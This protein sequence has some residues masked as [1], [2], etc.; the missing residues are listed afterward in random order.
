MNNR[1]QL[2]PDTMPEGC[3]PTY[4]KIWG[5]INEKCRSVRAHCENLWKDFRK[6]ADDHFL[7]E[8][9]LR[10]HQRW[11]EMYLTVS[12]IRAGFAIEDSDRKSGPDLLLLIGGRR[13][14]IEAVCTE[15]GGPGNPDSV[16]E[17]ETNV[18]RDIPLRQYVL[19]LRNSLQEKSNKLRQYIQDDIILP[20]DLTVVAINVGGIPF[21][22]VDMDECIKRS[23]YGIGDL[24]LSVNKSTGKLARIQRESLTSIAK[25]SGKPVGVR[26]LIDGSMEH[27]S[28]LLESGA[29]AANL[30]RKFGEDFIL[31]PNLISTRQWP[32]GILPLGREWRFSDSGEEWDG[33]LMNPLPSEHPP[34]IATTT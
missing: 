17:I 21:F 18:V 31:Y 25:S 27:I 12:L 3:C 24:S 29:N 6:H 5:G 28:A 13:L 26:C 7:T 20:G 16:P 34:S 9:S 8:F 11:F 33:E 15:N 19:R 23:V 22:A 30:P 32:Y 10:F 1:E 4:E 14:W 2:F